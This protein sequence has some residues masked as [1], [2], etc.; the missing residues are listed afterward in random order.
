M[1]SLNTPGTIPSINIP[2]VAKNADQGSTILTPIEE[3]KIPKKCRRPIK[4]FKMEDGA[5][6]E[7]SDKENVD[8]SESLLAFES[9]QEIN[10][11]PMLAAA[12]LE[13]AFNRVPESTQIE[14]KDVVFKIDI[15][16]AA[17][18]GIPVINLIKYIKTKTL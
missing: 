18:Q 1:M 13:I 3:E 6:D 14:Y 17:V 8:A 5:E 7:Y 10:S 4:R 12:I 16:R 2:D 9:L 11:S 15:S